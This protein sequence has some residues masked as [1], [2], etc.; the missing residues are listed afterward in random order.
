MNSSNIS[1]NIP[2]RSRRGRIQTLSYQLE[3]LGYGLEIVSINNRA[4]PPLSNPLA[5]SNK[6]RSSIQVSSFTY[7]Y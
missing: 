7:T 3:D 5:R 4:N 1:F 2:V 6:P